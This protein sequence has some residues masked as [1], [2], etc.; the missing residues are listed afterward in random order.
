M[1]LNPIPNIPTRLTI[2]IQAVQ[3]E[4]DEYAADELIEL[5]EEILSQLAAMG[6]AIYLQQVKQKEVFNDFVIS[7]FLS[8]GHEYN[9]GPLYRWVANMLKEAEGEK[10][11]LLRPFFWQTDAMGKEVLNQTIHQLASLRNDVMHGFFV[12]PPEKNREEAQKME[13]ILCAIEKVGLFTIEFGDFHFY[14]KFGF[15]GHWN[16]LE[17]SQWQRF[18]NCFHFGA[19]AR[20]ISY[21]YSNAFEAEEKELAHE[22]IQMDTNLPQKV[23]SFLQK[24]KGTFVCWYD[25]N[26]NKGLS[27]YQNILQ[28]IDTEVY[29]PIYYS[30]HEQGATFTA[31]FLIELLRK[32][33]FELTGKEKEIKDPFKFLKTTT[34]KKKPVL[35]LHNIHIGLFNANHLTKL[36]NACYEVSLP[37]FATSWHYPYLKRFVNAEEFIL[38]GNK[39]ERDASLIEIS[40]KNYIRFKGP[41]NEQEQEK[42]HFD[43][44]ETIVGQLNETLQKEKRVVARRFA[45]EFDYPIEFVHE[46]F[47]ILTPFYQVGREEFIKDEVDELYGFP[48]TIEESS[49]IY[50]SLGRR[51]VK[52]EYKHKVLI[53]N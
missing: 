28:S 42:E 25:P 27:S 8:N 51:D 39:T 32:E 31:A 26:S 9:A 13:A 1:K 17:P 2:K 16:V 47:S 15:S 36:F 10:A 7:L 46:A 35:I 22:S 37:I 45:D 30:L 19:L 6:L 23:V 4:E 3:S 43:L 33:L 18:E 14:N 50:L 44:L 41:S 5:G 12:L 40:L 49:R 24:G 29:F 20:R 34:L 53:Q 38:K 52:L 48:K 11:Q 21:E